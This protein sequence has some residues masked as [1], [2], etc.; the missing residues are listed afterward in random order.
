[1]SLNWEV[2]HIKDHEIVTTD[3]RDKKKWHP[4]TESLVWTAM[5]CGFNKITEENYEE[6]CKRVS[7][8]QRLYGACL[9]RNDGPLYLTNADIRAHI[10]LSTNVSAITKAQFI[11]KLGKELYSEGLNSFDSTN[12]GKSAMQIVQESADKANAKEK[13]NE[14]QNI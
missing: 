8:Y 1:M 11:S 9:S 4:V 7:A 6:I 2:K 10:G 5:A 14:N 3:P 12:H 13:T